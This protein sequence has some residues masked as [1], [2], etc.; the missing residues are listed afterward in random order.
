MLFSL[1]ILGETKE[2]VKVRTE[3][4]SIAPSVAPSVTAGVNKGNQWAICR[5]IML[6]VKNSEQP[7]NQDTLSRAGLML[8]HRRGR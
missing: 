5:K 8:S 3:A 1:K 4:D 7:K 2:E 6:L